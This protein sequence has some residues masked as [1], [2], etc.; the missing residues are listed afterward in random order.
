MSLVDPRSWSVL[1]FGDETAWIDFLGAHALWHDQLD[2]HIRTR[3]F[4]APISALP[5][6]DGG[7]AEWAKAHQRRHDD[8]CASLGISFGPDFESYDLTKADQFASWAFIHAQE[9]ARLA[10]IAA[11]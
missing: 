1:A 3:L 7:T 9:S 2:F 6:G 5:L 11:A 8:E 4:G 10:R